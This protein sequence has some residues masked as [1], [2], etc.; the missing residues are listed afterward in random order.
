[1]KSLNINLQVKLV[2]R[3]ITLAMNGTYRQNIK[4]T[5]FNAV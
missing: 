2:K 4:L 3:K 1:M 5:I